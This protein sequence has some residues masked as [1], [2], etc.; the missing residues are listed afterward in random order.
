MWAIFAQ[1][2]EAIKSVIAKGTQSPTIEYPLH[3]I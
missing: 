2:L 3:K 1:I